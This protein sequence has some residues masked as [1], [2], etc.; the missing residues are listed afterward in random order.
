MRIKK[1]FVP[2][3]FITSY[4][5]YQDLNKDK[6]VIMTVVQYIYEKVLVE[7]SKKGKLKISKKL[8]NDDG[9]IL[10]FKLM[11]RYITKNNYKWTNWQDYYY[12]L[13]GYL[14]SYIDKSI[15]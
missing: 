9:Y 13:K 4:F 14:L 6:K 5:E 3:P 12:P 11:E 7:L 1:Y 10:I 15:K 8:D 2:P